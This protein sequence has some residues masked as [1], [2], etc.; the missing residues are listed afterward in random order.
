MKSSKKLRG[1]NNH[2]LYNL[3]IPNY[4]LVLFSL[5]KDM[6]KRRSEVIFSF[7]IGRSYF[8]FFFFL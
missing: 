2:S 3:F 7:F 4:I 5:F 1:F 6:A 8:Y